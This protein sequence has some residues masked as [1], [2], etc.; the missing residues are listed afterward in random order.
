MRWNYLARASRIAVEKSGFDI[1]SQADE[2]F[3]EDAMTLYNLRR[4]LCQMGEIEKS[5][6]HV[7]KA[8]KLDGNFKMS[9]SDADF[10]LMWEDREELL[11]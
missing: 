6:E 7:G 10:A 11:I 1:L 9:T 5:K 2:N 8:I 3:P 4:Y